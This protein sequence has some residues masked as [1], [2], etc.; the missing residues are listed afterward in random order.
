MT[1]RTQ[2]TLC[3]IRIAADHRLAAEL[4][5]LTIGGRTAQYT[6]LTLFRR[7]C[8]FISRRM[9]GQCLQNLGRLP[10]MQPR[11]YALLL[12]HFHL[13]SFAGRQIVIGYLVSLL[14]ACPPCYLAGIFGFAYWSSSFGRSVCWD[15]ERR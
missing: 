6:I 14:T 2:H 10:E 3:R 9:A 13:P 15:K 5:A 4:P 11:L 1:Q 7:W 8:S 12:S